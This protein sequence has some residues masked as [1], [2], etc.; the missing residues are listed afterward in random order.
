MALVEMGVQ[1]MLLS[2]PEGSL[3]TRAAD[4]VSCFVWVVQGNDHTLPL[5][6]PLPR[7]RGHDLPPGTEREC[8]DSC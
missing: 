1:F 7:A 6:V 8:L 4:D 2:Q 5:P 3:R